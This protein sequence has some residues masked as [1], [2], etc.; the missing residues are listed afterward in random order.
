MAEDA[1]H[2][3]VEGRD[4]LIVSIERLL[5]MKRAVDPQRPKDMLDI[6]ELTRIKEQS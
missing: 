4:I 6:A 1:I 2:I 3:T 5:T